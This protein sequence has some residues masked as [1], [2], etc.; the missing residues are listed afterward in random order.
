MPTL[1]ICICTYK[2]P[3]GLARLLKAVTPQ[4]S[5]GREIVVVNDG[6]HDPAY[7]QALM[8]FRDTIRYLVNPSNLGVAESRNVVARAASGEYV[9]YIDDDCVP[10]SWWIDWID[11]KLE[12][13]P[14]LDI[15]AGPTRPL[16]PESG[17]TFMSRMQAHFGFIPQI[18]EWGTTVVFPTANLAV[19]RKFLLDNGGF[20][21][22][23]PFFGAAEDTEFANRAA[24]AGGRLVSDHHWPVWHDVGESYRSLA[25][26]YG[27]YGFSN[28]ALTVLATSPPGHDKIRHM[29]YSGLRWQFEFY[30]KKVWA[31]AVSHPGPLPERW[32]AAWAAL[33]VHMLYEYSAIRGRDKASGIFKNRPS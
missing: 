24:L 27:R 30:W 12:A 19:R 20:G 13:F 21:F 18:H 17:S 22:P 2:R 28:G 16:H 9:V 14:S 23:G 8:P 32:A 10:P 25:R 6:S 1:S 7:E 31:E 29:T 3:Q 11:A 26:R 33:G 15:V 4:V 5:T